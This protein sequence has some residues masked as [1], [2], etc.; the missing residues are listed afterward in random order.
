[1][2]KVLID[3]FIV[4]E[5]SRQPFLERARAVQSFPGFIEGFLYEETEGDGRQ[6]Y[7]TTAVWESPEAFENAKVSAAAE[8]KRRGFD[9]QQSTQEWKI[10][11]ERGV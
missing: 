5:E 9:P 10:Q 8:F 4:P 2:Q 1:M 3:I 7:V 6:N 11:S